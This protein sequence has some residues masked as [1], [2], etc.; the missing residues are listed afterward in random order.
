MLRWISCSI[1]FLFSSGAD[2]K[3]RRLP[4]CRNIFPPVKQTDRTDLI[5]WKD[6]DLTERVWWAGLGMGWCPGVVWLEG[7]A[8]GGRAVSRPAPRAR[9]HQQAGLYSSYPCHFLHQQLKPIY[10]LTNN[11]AIIG[12]CKHCL[13]CCF[14]AGRSQTHG[15]PSVRSGRRLSIRPEKLALFYFN[16]PSN[17]SNEF[18]RSP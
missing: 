9:D 3:P 11:W 14:T 15:R 6:S 12:F 5:E 13:G 1:G 16:C 17:Q 18:E 2:N 10:N 4:H 8:A 7:W